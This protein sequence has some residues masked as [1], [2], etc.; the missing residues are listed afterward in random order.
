[1]SDLPFPLLRTKLLQPRPALAVVPRQRLLDKLLNRPDAALL[2]FVASAGSGKTT[3]INQFLQQQ[4]WPVAWLSLDESDDDLVVFLSYVAAAVEN[5]F[6]GACGLT[7]KL[8][9]APQTPP[10]DYL[11]ATLVNELSDI[12]QPFALVLD[13]YHC[14]RTASIH[15]LTAQLL[16]HAPAALRLVISARYDP[17]LP[18]SR[19]ASQGKLVEIRAADLRFQV[20]EA[21]TLLEQIAGVPLPQERVAALVDEMEGWA[22]GLNTA[23]LSLRTLETRAEMEAG[24]LAGHQQRLVGILADEVFAVQPAEVR[25]FLMRTSLVSQLTAPLGE[26]L[27]EEAKP[28]QAARADAKAMLERLERDSLFIERLDEDHRW[29]RY[30]SLFRSFLVRILEQTLSSDEIATLHRRASFWY[31]QHG[32]A[33]EAIRHAL[34][35]RDTA[36]AADVIEADLYRMLQREQ[37]PMLER[38]L[39]LLP[40]AIIEQRPLLLVAQAWVQY[41]QFRM[42]PIPQLLAQAEAIVRATPHTATTPDVFCDLDALQTLML[43]ATG[44]YPLAVE[45]GQR[46]VSNSACHRT[47]S[48]GLAVFLLSLSLYAL[49]G[50]AP[51]IELL[52]RIIDDPLE[53]TAIKVQA[54][55]ALCHLGNLTCRPADQERAASA[56]LRLMEEQEL[57]VSAAWARHLLGRSFYERY[58]LE[59]AVRHFS[60]VLDQHYLAHFLCARDSFMWLALSYQ[61]LGRSQEADTVAAALQAFCVERGLAND[62]ELDTFS[63]RLALLQGDYDRALSIVMRSRLASV[64][65][66]MTAYETSTIQ[67]TTVLLLAGNEAQRRE[68]AS[69]LDALQRLAEASHSTW[70]LIRVLVLQAIALE[71]EGHSEQAL[72]ALERAVM[73]GYSGRPVASFVE[74]GAPVKRLL[75]RLTERGVAPAY[76]RHL[77]AAFPG[78]AAAGLRPAAGYGPGTM[79]RGADQVERLSAREIEVLAL[80]S[81]RL[82]N[83]EIAARLVISPLTVKRHVTNILQKLGVDSRWDAVE[84]ARAIGLIAPYMQ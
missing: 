36:L 47:Q 7:Q 1:M 46:V 51:A 17:P 65:L 11:A 57:D 80:L 6:P 73:L 3:L 4:G 37:W 68:A 25:D 10:V 66:P 83:K 77:L 33:S 76:V 19:L 14:L 69:S 54:Y 8:L 49:Q 34:L 75:Q 81:Q 72:A 18:L 78:S 27:L 2:L 32:S 30:H 64:P 79:S 71:Q 56:L 23:A 58:D 24:P 39:K 38:Q 26:A 45:C 61:G 60:L 55:L 5:V 21:Q 53:E 43:F 63:A 28:G 15:Q 35:A 62:P 31:W 16:R 84:R 59:E 50:E 70:H 13:D 52:T 67:Q 12:A 9:R 42:Q 20:A 29:Y 82:A 48:R 44:Q 40:A 41:Y 74:L 22:V